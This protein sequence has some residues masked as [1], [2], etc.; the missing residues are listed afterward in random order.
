MPSTEL[1]APARP[2]RK[3]DPASPGEPV[4]PEQAFRVMGE[5]PCVKMDQSLFMKIAIR[6][7]MDGRAEVY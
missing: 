7:K 3:E 5:R 2:S 4:A 1:I 6:L